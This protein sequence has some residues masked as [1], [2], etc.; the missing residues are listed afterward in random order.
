MIIKIAS[1]VVRLTVMAPNFTLDGIGA[2]NI[3]SSDLQL[4]KSYHRMALAWAVHPI[5][6][7]IGTFLNS[8]ILYMFYTER[9]TFIK[10]INAM[11]W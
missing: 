9:R 1:V 10:P 11:I 7:V 3:S 6:G 4:N 5:F 8:F 2:L